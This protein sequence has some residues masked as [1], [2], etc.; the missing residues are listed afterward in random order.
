MTGVLQ[1]ARDHDHYY[2]IHMQ[3]MVA[4]APETFSALNSSIRSIRFRR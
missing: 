2:V 1:C 4:A 3:D